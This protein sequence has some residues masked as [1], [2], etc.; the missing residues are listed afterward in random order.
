MIRQLRSVSL[1]TVVGFLNAGISFLLLPVLTAYLDPADYGVISLVNVYVSVLLPIVGLSTAGYVA[2]EYYNPAFPKKDFASLFSS[3]RVIPLVGIALLLIV[4][5]LGQSFLP[6]LMELPI[7]AYWMIVPLTLFSLYFQNF[8]SFLVSTKR[9]MLFS[10]T[11]L[12]KLLAEISLTIF[13][14]VGIGMHWEG[15]IQSALYTALLF[16]LVSVF[17]YRKWK[18]LS[19]DIRRKFIGQ[20]IL[21]GTPLIMHQIG[22][23]VIN[24]S[25]RLFLAKMVSVEEMGIYSV[26]YQVGTIVLILVTAFSNFFSPRHGVSARNDDDHHNGY[27]KVG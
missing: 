16:T 17:F 27:N 7:G 21:F 3:V 19:W 5:V 11:S 12:S 23:F 24:Q 9:A 4:F 18:L 14:V 13:L 10:T 20:A 26:G 1:Y 15:R 2:V 25:D 8:S 6:G 22:K